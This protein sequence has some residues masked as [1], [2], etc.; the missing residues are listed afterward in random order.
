MTSAEYSPTL[1]KTV[2]LGLIERGFERE[3]EMIH[4]FDQGKMMR[5]RITPI[6]AFDPEGTRIR[7]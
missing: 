4:L 3:G 1:G 7:G 2:A 6:C 5:A